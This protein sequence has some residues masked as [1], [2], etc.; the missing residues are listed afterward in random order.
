MLMYVVNLEED[1]TQCLHNALMV[2]GLLEAFD[3]LIDL[4][5]GNELKQ[6]SALDCLKKN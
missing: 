4:T 3:Y 6:V 5:L 1:R 2:A